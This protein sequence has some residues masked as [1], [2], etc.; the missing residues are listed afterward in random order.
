MLHW[1]AREF[2]TRG[3]IFVVRHPCAVV[4]SML[5]KGAWDH[6]KDIENRVNLLEYEGLTGEV[7][8]SLKEK[9]NPL[10]ES[11]S[12]QVEKLAIVWCLDQYIPLIYNAQYGYPW[13][14][15]PYERLVAYGESELE[16]ICNSINSEISQSMYDQIDKPSYSVKGKMYNSAERQLSKWCDRLSTQQIDAILGI[17]EQVG[18][19]H[20]YTSELEPNYSELNDLQRED[21]V[22]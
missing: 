19:S 15:A 17:V 9:F 20:I 5:D 22:W 1:T 7:S 11:S 13:I 21:A 18:L 2:S 16:R 3:I 8:N 6:W 10:I 12:T 14:I 4:A